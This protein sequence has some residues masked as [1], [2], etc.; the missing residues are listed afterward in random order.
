MRHNRA[1]RK[2]G[3][4]SEHRRALFRNQLLSL[5]KHERIITTLPKAKELRPIAERM[6]TLGRKNSVHARRL[7]NRWI[8]D[9]DLIK[10]L[11][12]EIAPRFATRPGG[13]TR[14]VKLGPRKG[15][16][17]ELAILE[18]VDYKLPEA[19]KAKEAK[20]EKAKEKSA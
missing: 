14:I 2:L 12:S 16:G 6:V 20:E 17:A 18:F 3:R 10:K 5:I 1:G 7:V 13:Y 4:V 15:D 11:F 8:S 9:R 19:K